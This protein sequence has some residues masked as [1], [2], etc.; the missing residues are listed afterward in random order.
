MNVPNQTLLLKHEECITKSN[1]IVQIIYIIQTDV[2][3][4]TEE[5]NTQ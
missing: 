1:G 5:K 2:F 4:R 3:L